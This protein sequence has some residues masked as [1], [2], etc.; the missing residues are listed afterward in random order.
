MFRLEALT[1]IQS[2]MEEKV[3]ITECPSSMRSK[4]ASALGRRTNMLKRRRVVYMMWW[5]TAEERM[6]EVWKWQ[7]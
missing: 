6:F 3:T 5:K 1:V 7:C 2:W 4:E